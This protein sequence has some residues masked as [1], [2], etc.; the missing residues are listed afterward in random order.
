M[1]VAVSAT[2]EESSQVKEPWRIS[3]KE[4]GSLHKKGQTSRVHKVSHWAVIC[5]LLLKFCDVKMIK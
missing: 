4:P 5:D 3:R 2:E 1:E